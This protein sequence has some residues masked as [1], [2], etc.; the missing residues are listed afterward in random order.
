MKTL[1]HKLTHIFLFFLKITIALIIFFIAQFAFNK[2]ISIPS[3]P[4]LI[5]LSNEIRELEKQIKDERYAQQLGK[6]IFAKAD[7]SKDSQSL[8]K[9]VI[10]EKTGIDIKEHDTTLEKQLMD[11]K[12]AYLIAHDKFM[13]KNSPF[14]I[15]LVWIALII[16]GTLLIISVIPMWPRNIQDSL[17][18]VS[19]ISYCIAEYGISFLT[20]NFTASFLRVLTI[21]L[22]LYFQRKIR[23]LR[24]QNK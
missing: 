6:E 14:Y 16:A 17:V 2:Y 13:S 3:D 19:F 5:K 8:L 24:L 11:K 12:C 18:I 15:I 23:E 7:L 4:E 21:A 1:L 22:Y 10:K 9:Q 20:N